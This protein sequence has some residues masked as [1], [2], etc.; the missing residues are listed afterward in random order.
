MAVFTFHPVKASP[1]ARAASSPP[2]TSDCATS[3][4]SSALTGSRPGDDPDEGAWFQ[5]QHL[6]GFNYRL[7]DL[8]A[9]LGVSQL[10]RLEEFVVRRNAI[11]ERYREAFAGYATSDASGRPG[12]GRHAHH[13]FVVQRRDGAAARRAL[14]EGLREREIFAQVHYVPVYRHPYYRETYGYERGLARRPS[15]TTRAASPCRASRTLTEAEQDI[16]VTAVKEI[17]G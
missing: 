11:A 12:G 3:W 2:E 10:R 14:Y 7:T 17:V 1:P 13:L 8:Q 9:A 15:T 6:L 16:V 5:E 4:R